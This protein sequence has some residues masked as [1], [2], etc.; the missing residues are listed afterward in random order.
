[1]TVISESYQDR[2]GLRDT[3]RDLINIVVSDLNHTGVA[4][5]LEDPSPTVPARPAVGSAALE[6]QGHLAT[7]AL[8]ATAVRQHGGGQ[9]RHAA[10]T[11]QQAGRP[12]HPAGGEINSLCCAAAGIFALASRHRAAHA[13]PLTGVRRAAHPP[14]P[15][16]SSPRRRAQPVK[17]DEHL[18]LF[19][20]RLLLRRGWKCIKRMPHPETQLFLSE[21]FYPRSDIAFN[22]KQRSHIGKR[23]LSVYQKP[24]CFETR[25]RSS[26]L[27]ETLYK[28]LD[29]AF[30]ITTILPMLLEKRASGMK[31]NLLVDLLNFQRNAEPHQIRLF[32]FRFVLGLMN[33][34]RNDNSDCQPHERSY[35]LDPAGRRIAIPDQF[36]R[37]RPRHWE[38]EHK[39][40]NHQDWNDRPNK[41]YERP[42][43]TS[44]LPPLLWYH[45]T[46]P[47]ITHASS[48][49]AP[50][51][52]V[53]RGAA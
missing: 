4:N 40:R 39:Q 41:H 2:V 5:A 44:V 14:A 46:S 20:S 15:L 7:A 3:K 23:L 22:A 16:R 25:C 32:L 27:S 48:L 53:H 29:A 18:A 24:P 47:P 50:T 28:K 12:T 17:G 8:G 36:S 42:E 10:L 43:L 34:P 19:S 26:D 38:P 6:R 13:Y 21:L 9:A 35:G 52:L 33:I 11:Q 31:G 37:P 49:P 30:V 45:V 51:V 1:M